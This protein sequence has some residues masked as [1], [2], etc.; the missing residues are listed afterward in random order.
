[1]RQRGGMPGQAL[2]PPQ[3]PPPQRAP[4]QPVHWQDPGRA[5]HSGG[6]GPMPRPSAVLPMPPNLGPMMRP[7]QPAPGPK[8]QRPPAG[9]PAHILPHFLIILELHDSAIFKRSG[10]SQGKHEPHD[11]NT[12]P[13]LCRGREIVKLANLLLQIDLGMG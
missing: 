13:L 10:V 4:R 2:P 8:Q 9:M 1:M 12:S 3:P 6:D 11:D 7:F 5:Q